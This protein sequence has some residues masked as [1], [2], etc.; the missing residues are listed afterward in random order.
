MSNNP[1]LSTEKQAD[2]LFRTLSWLSAVPVAWIVI[3]TFA[4]VFGRYV[5]SSPVRGSVEMIE[6]A[7]AMVIFTA[8][9]LITR[10]RGHVTVSLIDGMVTGLGKKI[11]QVVCDAISALALG[12]LTWRLYLQ[13]QDDVASGSATIVLSLPHAPLSFVMAFFAAL[14]TLM[15]MGLMVQTFKN[16][17]DAV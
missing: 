6:F 8:L 5:F 4:D 11:K 2:V 1:S 3:L 15:L 7:M 13:G 12:V 16:T 9:P 14:S 10:Q 17:G